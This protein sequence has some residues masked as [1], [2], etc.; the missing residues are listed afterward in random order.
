[1]SSGTSGSGADNEPNLG[2]EQDNPTAE[3]VQAM[4]INDSSSA[5]NAV[6]DGDR[7]LFLLMEI[8]DSS[9]AEN[10]V[11]DGDRDLF[12]L[13]LLPS[14]KLLSASDKREILHKCHRVMCNRLKGTTGG[15]S[16]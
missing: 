1:M 5:E 8:N 15:N 9:S 7:D 16:G 4:E 13:Y 12:L 10:A 14:Y 2:T 11:I 3:D 6:I